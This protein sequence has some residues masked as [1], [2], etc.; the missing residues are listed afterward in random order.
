GFAGYTFTPDLVLSSQTATTNLPVSGNIV[1]EGSEGVVAGSNVAVGLYPK[2]EFDANNKDNNKATGYSITNGNVVTIAHSDLEYN[3]QYVLEVWENSFNT[4]ATPTRANATQTFTYTTEAAPSELIAVGPRTVLGFDKFANDTYTSLKLSSDNKLEIVGSTTAN[5]G[6]VISDNSVTLAGNSFTKKA[7]LQ[8]GG[9]SSQGCYIHFKVSG[10]CKITVYNNS[11]TLARTLK[12]DKGA[13]GTSYNVLSESNNALT[14]NYNG[15]ATD[16]YVYSAGSGIEV[17]GIVIE[18]DLSRSESTTYS[19]AHTWNFHEGDWGST[20]T[21]LEQ[22]TDWSNGGS[23]YFYHQTFPSDYDGLS[24]IGFDNIDVIKGLRF[25]KGRY[26]SLDYS[27]EWKHMYIDNQ[28]IVIPGLVNGQKVKLT[29]Y[30]NSG[31][32]NVTATN[33]TGTAALTTTQGSVYE[34]TAT[35]GDVTLNFPNPAWIWK[36]EVTEVQATWEY[37][38]GGK[39][40]ADEGI[41]ISG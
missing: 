6:V 28:Q 17:Y 25:N 13:I 11:E 7:Y 23:G 4:S 19:G 20:A 8:G 38:E 26:L 34:F 40:T 39:I 10:N 36:I 16:F 1:L 30:T 27:S 32:C 15:G 29:A 33:A 31:G 18:H 9:S 2:S 35:G 21:Q 14:Y 41:V 22:Y 5:R 37:T 24:T 3:T 12:L